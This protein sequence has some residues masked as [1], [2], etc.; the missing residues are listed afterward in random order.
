MA[1][2]S[3]CARG[4]NCSLAA[5]HVVLGDA[6][7]DGA[8]VDDGEAS[9]AAL[10]LVGGLVVHL[11]R[12]GVHPFRQAHGGGVGEA[13]RCVDLG[14]DPFA[15]DDERGAER[16]DARGGLGISQG[17]RDDRPRGSDH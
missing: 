8:V 4:T 6:Q 13:A 10:R 5:Q 7:G 3:R 17:G 1:I 9:G 16:L 11:S 2:P 12:D 14:G 15:V